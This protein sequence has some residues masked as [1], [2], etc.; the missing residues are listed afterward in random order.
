MDSIQ[1][2]YNQRE[3]DIL[4]ATNSLVPV[5]FEEIY[6]T[7][8]GDRTALSSELK[9][10][11]D[12]ELIKKVDKKRII[13]PKGIEKLRQLGLIFSNENNSDSIIFS[14]NN[15]AG[16]IIFPIK[17]PMPEEVREHLREDIQQKILEPMHN[18][19]NSYESYMDGVP[20]IIIGWSEGKGMNFNIERKKLDEPG[21]VS[22]TV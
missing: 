5:G 12:R 13:T 14:Q 18:I 8:M 20:K 10:L 22:H 2:S 1:I 3:I 19:V 21:T 11:E 16:T 7:V 17:H 9:N 4:S 15:M 6:F